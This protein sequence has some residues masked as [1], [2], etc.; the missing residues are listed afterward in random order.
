MSVMGAWEM[1][2]AA[3]VH[4]YL[5]MGVIPSVVADEF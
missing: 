5:Q 1:G 3:V 2:G 4:L